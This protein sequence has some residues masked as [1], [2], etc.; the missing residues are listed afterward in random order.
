MVSLAALAIPLLAIWFWCPLNR[1]AMRLRFALTLITGM[2]GIAPAILLYLL[3]TGAVPYISIAPWQVPGGWILSTLLMLVIFVLL[4]DL[5]WLIARLTGR[6]SMAQIMHIPALSIGAL[7]VAAGLSAI[8][9]F[10]ALQPPRVHEQQI[11]VRNLPAAL[12]GLRIAV[13]AD[14][15]ASP[16]NDASYVQTIV[17]RTLATTPDLIVLPGDMVDGDVATSRSHVAPLAGLSARYGVWAAPGNH[18]YYSGYNAWR[19][20]FRRLGLNL[21]ENRTQLLSIKGSKLALSGIGDPVFGR[22]SPNNADPEEAEGIPPDVDAVAAQARKA[23]AAFHILLAH[24]PKFA[25]DNAGKGVNLQISGHTH[26]G[27]I[28]GMDRWLVAPVNNGF[29][30]GEYDVGNMKLLVSSGA[31]LWAGFAV[32]LGVAPRIELLTLVAQQ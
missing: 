14:I 15:H 26:G 20:E 3:Q 23:G 13:L 29:V 1:I 16:V 17:Q 4:R 19:A 21:L 32:R 5:L 7:V 24:Q 9:V 12:Q 8:G 22:T 10:N 30:R 18:E 6:N 25:R 28:L 11:A 31:G 27:L 2:L